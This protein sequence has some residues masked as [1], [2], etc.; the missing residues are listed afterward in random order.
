MK[1]AC[2]SVFLLVVSV[3]GCVTKPMV[4]IEKAG[5]Q[6]TMAKPLSKVA[7][8]AA[9]G[10]H[11]C[12]LLLDGTVKCWGSN[13]VGQLGNETVEKDSTTPVAVVGISNVKAIAAGITYTCVILSNGRVKCWG[14]DPTKIEIKTTDR[15]VF[16]GP[17][18]IEGITN[19][20]AI[21][22]GWYHTCVILS[23]GKVK[24]WGG[25]PTGQLGDGTTT[26]STTPVEVKGISQAVAIA[27]G[28]AHTCAVISNGT[29]KCWGAVSSPPGIYGFSSHTP[30]DI[31][32]IF[33]ATAVAGGR[34]HACALLSDGTVECW[35]SNIFGQLGNRTV[36]TSATPLKAEDISNAIAI[37]AG[38]FRTCTL[39]S[40]GT[41][42][43][44]G[45]VT[46][47]SKPLGVSP[48]FGTV[49]GISNAI[50]VAVGGAHICALLR[51]ATVKCWAE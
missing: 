40:D 12:A 24:C 2:G 9:G 14:V 19:A 51:D 17:V 4:V 42:K 49:D 6:E 11:T 5:D 36:S 45:A 25:N 50:G 18:Q 21:T 30:I 32:N 44:W 16:S 33:N 3:A 35:G 23:G 46:N 48:V 43:C 47:P 26:N 37:S 28:L 34:N 7:A 31:K 38:V 39:H 13:L 22:T 20:T 27:A 41:V 15:K 8:I 1:K 29:V 10:G